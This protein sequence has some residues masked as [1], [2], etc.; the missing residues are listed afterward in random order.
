[1]A[2]PNASSG[3][4]EEVIVPSLRDLTSDFKVFRALPSARRRMI[5]P[6]IS[7]DHFGPTQLGAGSKLNISPHPHIGVS[8]LTYLLAGE[9]IH[10]NSLGIVQ[11]IRAGDANWMTAGR[12]I[13]HS[14]RSPPEVDGGAAPLLGQQ[15]WVALPRSDEERQPSFSHHPECDLP[16]LEADGVSL[17]VI[18]GEAFNER[19][20][21]PVHSDLM[22]VDVVL[23]PGARLT[24]PVQHIERAAFVVSG[25]I[26][27]AGQDGVFREAQLVL[28]KPDAEIVLRAKGGAHAMLLGGEPFPEARYVYW[29]F[30]SSSKDRIRQAIDDWSRGCFPN[31]AE[32][33]ESLPLPACMPGDD[34]IELVPSSVRTEQNSQWQHL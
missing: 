4:V 12:G 7:L 19:S 10:R 11:S 26:E 14:E 32:E 9:I 5:G 33:T 2:I 34:F 6:F 13:V 25:E 3:P 27:V 17:T 23:K 16:G 1:M 15:I 29:N 31:I 20:P 18:A 8:I 24:V 22:Y 21:V 30:V 28:F